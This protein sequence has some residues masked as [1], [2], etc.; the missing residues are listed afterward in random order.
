MKR[1][2]Q[3][4]SCQNHL[5]YGFIGKPFS[6]NF[7]HSLLAGWH[8]SLLIIWTLLLVVSSF[9]AEKHSTALRDYFKCL[10]L[11]NVCVWMRTFCMFAVKVCSFF[12]PILKSTDT[13]SITQHYQ[14]LPLQQRKSKILFLVCF[15]FGTSKRTRLS[16]WSQYYQRMAGKNFSLQNSSR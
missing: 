10:C 16:C 5:F 1:F 7:Y 3:E 4:N 15:W 9:R 14:P 6:C 2:L 13:V 11:V 8:K 12:Y